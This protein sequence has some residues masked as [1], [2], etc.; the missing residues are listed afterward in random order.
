[1]SFILSIRRRIFNL[2]PVCS[3]SRGNQNYNGI[4]QK[5]SLSIPDEDFPEG[6][7]DF[8]IQTVDEILDGYQVSVY[9]EKEEQV[10]IMQDQAPRHSPFE[11]RV[12]EKGSPN[13]S[14]PLKSPK[15]SLSS[16]QKSTKPKEDHVPLNTKKIVKAATRADIRSKTESSNLYEI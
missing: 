5:K 7:D 8:S 1:M 4:K 16:K 10:K 9:N 15:K 11:E 3:S 12:H 14:S 2:K 13:T 6:E